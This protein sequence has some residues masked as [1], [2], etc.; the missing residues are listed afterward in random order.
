VLEIKGRTGPIKQDD[1]RQVVQWA[2]DAQLRDG[3]AYKP[4]IVGNP[5]C[6]LPLDQRGATLAPNAATYAANGGVAVI[7]TIQLFEALRRKQAGT[8]DA[9]SFWNTV[10]ASAGAVEAEGPDGG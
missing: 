6:D 5:H 2:T 7:T 10:F 4:I 8:F 3:I 1:V 9:A